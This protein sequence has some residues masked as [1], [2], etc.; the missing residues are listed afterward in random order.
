MRTSIS[1]TL[2]EG[3]EFLCK[4]MMFIHSFR[5]VYG[6]FTIDQAECQVSGIQWL[7]KEGS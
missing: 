4:V 2:R 7:T 5:S 6:A 3:Y 1:S